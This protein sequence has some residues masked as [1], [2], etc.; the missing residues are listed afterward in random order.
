MS[1]QNSPT[2][3]IEADCH[4][5]NQEALQQPDDDGQGSINSSHHSYYNPKDE[6]L[7][8]SVSEPYRY[9]LLVVG[10]V[11]CL[12]ASFCYTFALFSQAMAA[13]AGMDMTGIS[14]AATV[15]LVFSYF[16]LPYAFIFDAF[17]PKPVLIIGTILLPLGCLLLAL[18]F[19][20]TI[21]ATTVN[22]SVFLGIMGGGCIVFDI[23]TVVSVLS[24]FP[25]SRGPV[26]A[27]MKTFAGL[28]TAIVACLEHAFFEHKEANLF[29]FLMS[30]SLGLGLFCVFSMQL[31]PYHLTGRQEKT[32]DDDAKAARHRTK[33][34]FLEQRPPRLR[35][36]V[37]FV[38]VVFLII[39]LPVQSAAVAYASSVSHGTKVGLAIVVIVAL[40][41]YPVI[42][43]PLPF[44]GGME[45]GHSMTVRELEA[46]KLSNNSIFSTGPNSFAVEDQHAH[47]TLAGED[48]EIADEKEMDH[49]L[50]F[51]APQFQTTFCQSLMTIR[52]WAIFAACFAI[53]GAQLVIIF[54][55]PYIC[56]ALRGK[57]TDAKF[58]ALLG[59][60]SGVGSAIGRLLLAW[61]EVFTQDRPANERIPI[62][63][64]FFVPAAASLLGL[65]LYLVLPGDGLAA[66]HFIM[67]IGNGSAA[68][69]AVLVFRGIFAKEPAKH[70]NFG[71]LAAMVSAILLNRVVFGEWYSKSTQ[72]MSNI[73]VEM[74]D[75]ENVYFCGKKRCVLM[76]LLVMLGLNALS[77]LAVTY[78]HIDYSRYARSV[79]EKHTEKIAA[80]EER[81]ARRRLA[82]Q[83]ANAAEAEMGNKLGD[84]EVANTDAQIAV[85]DSSSKGTAN[86]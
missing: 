54:Y 62:T 12:I 2:E 51:I 34:L 39:Y 44:L 20:G 6:F 58:K 19:N 56:A 30:C 45:E 66:A 7:D 42:C 80:R 83:E 65:V 53:I 67:S 85:E 24:W 9:F 25:T 60:L 33:Q 86:K 8:Y 31:P 43:L 79:V 15:M 40:V 59:A 41:L 50:E 78:V 57:W 29:F 36:I 69:A 27:V 75:G 10:S 18:T 46:S 77:F 70:Y 63:V 38:F 72:D 17:G 37:A 47:T 13:K 11:G 68:A 35:M 76:P 48:M 52:L 16:T 14:A 82:A 1:K 64:V 23:G 32:L 3:P 4:P 26:V 5:A 84:E 61:L 55:Y 22:F 74:Y 81:H 71:F 28:G 73:V 21:P 49:D